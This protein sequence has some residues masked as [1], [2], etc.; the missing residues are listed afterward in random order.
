M[1]R[2]GGA[3]AVLINKCVMSREVLSACPGLRYI[4]VQATGYNVV[5]LPAAR[6]L[7]ITVTN[8][9]AYSTASVAQHTVA[10][11][12][13]LT[14]KVAEHDAAVHAGR[15][16][17]SPDF[18]FW[19]APLT[20]LEGKTLGIIGYGQ[21][22]RRV[23]R[24]A[25][26]MGMRVLAYGPHPNDP[27]MTDLDTVLYEADIL[28]L[29]CPL[30]AENRGFICR[31]NIHRMRPGVL[32]VNTARGGLVNEDQLCE[33]LNCGYV[34]GAALDVVDTEP[35]RA[36]NPLLTAPNCVITPHIAWAPMETRQRLV[37]ISVENLRAWLNGRPVNVVS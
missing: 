37:D 12:L 9:P 34:R 20:E 5:D 14:N 11:M 10:L 2:I 19:D 18:C 33:A 4:G 28:T 15:W 3:E 27:H 35:M 23:G 22:G 6:E 24:I 21:I 32:I 16:V 31:D 29:H 8:I 1:A 7:G 36:D 17:T 13:A 30:T 26:A 25:E